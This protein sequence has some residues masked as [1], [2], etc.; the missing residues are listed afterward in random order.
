MMETMKFED[1]SSA[2]ELHAFLKKKGSNHTGGYFH[3]SN[4]GALK[5]MLG[6]RKL[7]FSSGPE[8][9]DWLE[10]KK[11]SPEE[12]KRIY[13]ASF[14]FGND[15]NMAMW[16]LYGEPLADALRI[17]F[18]CKSLR[19]QIENLSCSG[20]DGSGLYQVLDNGDYRPLDARFTIELIDVAYLSH[21]I[22]RNTLYW[23]TETLR[24]N[25]QSYLR[26]LYRTPSFAGCLKNVAWR[27]E[28]ESRILIKLE[29]RMPNV[30]KIAI[31]I[32]DA[33]DDIAVLCG[34]CLEA[35]HLESELGNFTKEQIGE[36]QSLGQIYMRDKCA[37][38]NSKD[39]CPLKT[40]PS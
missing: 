7:H 35:G 17:K 18:R 25:Q 22:G 28:R 21:R 3:Y 39:R 8:M 30:K 37:K 31:D 27:Y 38:C 10:T 26:E 34:P 14:S 13:V 6:S 29:S 4:I 24:E 11:G 32:G 9:N 5:G 15:E 19:H 23:N 1:L 12:W 20:E 2:Q 40:W 36:S 33:L 16:A